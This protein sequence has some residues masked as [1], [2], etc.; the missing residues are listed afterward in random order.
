MFRRSWFYLPLLGALLLTL[1]L[2]VRSGMFMRKNPGEPINAAMRIALEK[3]HFEYS[4]ADDLRINQLY[5]T[6]AETKDGLR[7]VVTAHGTRDV[8]P[9]VGDEVTVSYVG[10]VLDGPI[11]SQAKSLTYRVGTGASLKG[12]DE[13]VLD[14]KPGEERTVIVPWW[15]GYGAD[16]SEPTIP[17]KATLIFQLKLIDFR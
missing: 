5:T 14:M 4:T 8:K 12:L 1:A 9:Q 10:R 17:P 2:C 6:F 7:F 11:F 15:L 13:A 16:G 3:H